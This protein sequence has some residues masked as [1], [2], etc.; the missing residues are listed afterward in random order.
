M[1][2]DGNERKEAVRAEKS[3]PACGMTMSE[4]RRTGLLGCAY[5]YSAFRAE[6]YDTVRKM[7]GIHGE[8]R[9]RGKRP[10]ASAE[11]KYDSA[12]DYA[13]RRERLIE[14]SEQAM[15]AGDYAAV[16]RLKGELQALSGR[17][18]RKGG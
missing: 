3:C 15:R 17:P 6:L 16:E 7:H 18:A 1:P 13:A 4:F 5:C 9:H 2:A 8:V 12:R 11:E 10:E 14:Q